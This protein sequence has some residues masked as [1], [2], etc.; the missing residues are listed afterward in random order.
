[1]PRVCWTAANESFDDA[2]WR[3]RALIPAA[4]LEGMGW[5]SALRGD[6][7]QGFEDLAAIVIDPEDEGAEQ[8]AR[9][10]GAAGAAVVLD[11]SR[12]LRRESGPLDAGWTR[13]RRLA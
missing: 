3:R 11:V 12:W 8:L 4:G 10:G 1:M 9:R 2:H 5:R 6:L 7:E 13:L